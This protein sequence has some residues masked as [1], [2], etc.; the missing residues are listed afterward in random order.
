MLFLDSRTQPAWDLSGIDVYAN[1]RTGAQARVWT[2]I[3]VL[4]ETAA[5][6][7]PVLCWGM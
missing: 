3:L 7:F 4:V 5:R 1:N 6:G 2:T